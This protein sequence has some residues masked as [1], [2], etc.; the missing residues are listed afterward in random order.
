MPASANIV[1][2]Q[3]VKANCLA[4][5]IILGDACVGLAAKEFVGR[6]FCQFFN[7]RKRYAFAYHFVLDVHGFFH[8]LCLIFSD[9][10][11]IA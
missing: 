8:V 9:S 5:L 2:V 4:P 6:L 11:H 3:D 10:Y 7:L 1:G